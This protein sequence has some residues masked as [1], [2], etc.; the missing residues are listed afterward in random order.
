MLAF[1]V[2]PYM[3]FAFIS[4]YIYLFIYLLKKKNLRTWRILLRLYLLIDTCGY[5]YMQNF[6][7]V[8]CVAVETQAVMLNDFGSPRS[9]Y[10]SSLLMR[11][12]Q[13]L[14]TSFAPVYQNIC[15]FLCCSYLSLTH[16]RT[17][18]QTV[19]HI[20]CYFKFARFE[21]HFLRYAA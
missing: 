6:G 17:N 1:A 8:C 2:S 3:V 12:R 21:K 13:M 18:S 10:P 7:W 4:S 15:E 20:L 9:C 5:H 11:L 19:N 16:T 14:C